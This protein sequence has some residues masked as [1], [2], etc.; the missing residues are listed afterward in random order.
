MLQT[1][2]KIRNKKKSTYLVTLLSKLSTQTVLFLSCPRSI[3]QPPS[4]PLPPSIF[5]IN[6]SYGGDRSIWKRAHNHRITGTLNN[7]TVRA[8]QHSQPTPS[9]DSPFE[10]TKRDLL[11]AVRKKKMKM[12]PRKRWCKQPV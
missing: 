11:L 2:K 12:N 5:I 4:N 6:T 3:F 10:S 7:N 1:T 8:Y 9:F